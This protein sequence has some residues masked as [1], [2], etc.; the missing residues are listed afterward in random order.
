MTALLISLFVVGWVAA[1]LIGTQAYFR[2]EQ[3]KPIHERNWRSAS[4]DQ[5][6]QS[7]T[8]QSTDFGDRVPAY[9]GDAF[10][11]NSL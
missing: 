8:G 4:F 3:S 1:A 11:S 5:L 7:V 6:A 9:S 10:T 2:G